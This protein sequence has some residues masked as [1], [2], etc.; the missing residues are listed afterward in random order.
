MNS[1]RLLSRRVRL[2]ERVVLVDGLTRSGKSILGPILAT[3][4][5]V[6]IERIEP[7]YEYIAYLDSA[8][9]ITRD[10]AVTMLRIHA[11]THLFDCRLGRNSNFRYSDHSSVFNTPYFLRFLKRVFLKDV[12]EELKNVQSQRPYFQVQTHDILSMIDP[13]FEAFGDDLKVIEIVRDPYTLI[14]SWYNRG[15]GKRFS[16]DPLSYKITCNSS[17]G[18]VP[19]YAEE[20]YFDLDEMDKIIHMIH[21]LTHKVMKKYDSFDKKKQAQVLWTV[22]EDFVT[23][24]NKGLERIEKYLGESRTKHTIKQMKKENC[25]RA[26]NM[27][28]REEKKNFVLKNANEESKKMIVDLFDI[29]HRIRDDIGAGV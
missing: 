14:Y 27:K 10:A 28:D 3:L 7:I 4:S 12:G 26:L 15:W 21:S 8:E 13:L 2:A 24:S 11:D 1:E 5:N 19:W 6:E 9:K 22:Y 18:I 29:Y 25:P 16:E 17:K 23:N 20:E